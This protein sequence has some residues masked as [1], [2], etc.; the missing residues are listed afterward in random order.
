MEGYLYIKKLGYNK[1]W[2]VLDGQRLSYYEDIDLKL[3]E[4]K[5]FKGVLLLK[6]AI[7]K[8]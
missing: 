8:V 4:P 5:G 3:Q 2:A 6:E 1:V 7:V